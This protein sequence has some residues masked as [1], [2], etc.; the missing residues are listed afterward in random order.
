MANLFTYVWEFEVPSTAEAEFQRHYGPNGTWVTLFRH[1]PA[2]VETLLLQDS[3]RP[4]RYLTVDRWKSADAYHSFRERF[5]E[6]YET[7]DRLC[8]TLTV[9]ETHL[10]SFSDFGNGSAI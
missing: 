2:Y 6:Q 3:S 10:G 7:L 4:G 5:A 9:R 1:D 8:E